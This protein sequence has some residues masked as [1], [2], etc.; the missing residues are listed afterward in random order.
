MATYAGADLT[1]LENEIDTYYTGSELY[2]QLNGMIRFDPSTG[3]SVTL[4]IWET[5]DPATQANY[6]LVRYEW[7]PSQATAILRLTWHDYIT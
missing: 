4:E 6:D 1:A 3:A 7:D 5:L 2:D